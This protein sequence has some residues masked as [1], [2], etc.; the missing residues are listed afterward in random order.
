MPK[1]DKLGAWLSSAH[2]IRRWVKSR[3]ERIAHV[4]LIDIVEFEIRNGYWSVRML[5]SRKELR[6]LD[7]SEI[8]VGNI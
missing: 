8:I 6:K 3:N 4:Y 7:A 1:A 5:T 2:A